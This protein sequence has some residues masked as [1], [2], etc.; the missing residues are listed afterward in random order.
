MRRVVV[1]YFVEPG[2]GEDLIREFL[3][4]EAV[5]NIRKESGCLQYE[6]FVSVE[7]KDHVTL[8][9]TWENQAA[10]EAHLAGPNMAPLGEIKQKY[11]NGQNIEV[12]DKDN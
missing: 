6:Y 5:K 2:M 10:H 4:S 11:T 12:I 7:D 9:E 8:L 1:T 3:A